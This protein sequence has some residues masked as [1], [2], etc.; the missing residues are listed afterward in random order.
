MFFS[1]G[2]V[3]WLVYRK[4]VTRRQ[5][6][7][8]ISHVKMAARVRLYC[9]QS[10]HKKITVGWQTFFL[11]KYGTLFPNQCQCHAQL[12]KTIHFIALL[13]STHK[14][15]LY[16][17]RWTFIQHKLNNLKYE[18]KL[19]QYYNPFYIPLLTWECLHF[20]VLMPGKISDQAMRS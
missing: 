19:P 9:E 13:G 15:C 2:N 1:S 18:D 17:Y 7:H 6:T 8:N 5:K 12:C 16:M 4:E 3:K 11:L 14:Q 20:L 10:I